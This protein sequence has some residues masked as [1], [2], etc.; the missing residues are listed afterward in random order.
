MYFPTA[1][2]GVSHK[3]PKIAKMN[4]LA[5]L[6][7]SCGDEDRLLG[8]FMADYLRPGEYPQFP[9]T[10]Q[11]GIR[12]HRFIDSFTDTHP[13][14]REATRI[15]RPYHS[16][17]SP[18]VIDIYYD[19]FLA[20]NWTRFSEVS[21]AF[22]TRTQYQILER[23]RMDMPPILQRRL[24]GMI[25][26]DWLF[27]QGGEEGIARTFYFLRKRASRPELLL[28]ATRHLYELR[29]PLE[30]LFLRF[31]PLLQAEVNNWCHQ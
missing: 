18:V 20:Q 26:D 24:P 21:L 7:L 15:L 27:R 13:L 1:P 25:Q 22:F 4:H 2:S 14:N 28:H 19:F 16:K 8:N 23:R 29:S 17:Y 6:F 9:P 10:V 12:L 30:S 31:F 11:Q 3:G 5:H